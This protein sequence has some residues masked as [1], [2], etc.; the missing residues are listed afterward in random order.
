MSACVAQDELRRET[1]MTAQPLLNRAVSLH[2]AGQLAEAERLYGEVLEADPKSFPAHYMFAVLLYQQQRHPAALQAVEAALR[3]NPEV[4]EALALHGVLALGAGDHEKALASTSKVVAQNPQDAEAWHNRGVILAGMGRLEEALESYDKALALRPTPEAWTNRGAAL[5][6][7]KRCGD[8]LK[9]Y[10]AALAF[11]ANLV[12]ALAGRGN[13]L[14]ELERYA[15]AVETFDAVLV[16]APSAFEAWSNRGLALH[17]MGRFADALASYDKAIEARSDYG[18]AWTNRGK[19]LYSLERYEDA[20]GSYDRAVALAPDSVQAWHARAHTLRTLHRLPEALT[21]AEKALVAETDFLP[22]LF[23]RGWLL[24]ELNRVSE[25]LAAMKSAA[26]LTTRLNVRVEPPDLPHRRRHDEEQRDYLESLGATVV[27]GEIYFAGGERVEG[28]A[29]N[30]ENAEGACAQW[31]ETRPRLA[32]IDNFLTDTALEKL[33]RFC[34]GST[35]WGTTYDGGYVG[36]TPEQGF[37]CPL[38]AQVAE[39]L[40]DLV[41]AIIGA[42]PLRMLW[43]FKY[44]SRLGGTKIHA[45]QAAINVNFWITPDEANLN[46][47]SGGMVIWDVA[48]PQDW[49]PKRYNGDEEAA[50]AF[51][52]QAGAKPITVPHRSN[53]AVIFDSDLF[54][55]TDAINFK[56]GYLNRRIN[57]TM[58]F[59]RRTYYGA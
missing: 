59:G 31:H 28:P 10:D 51:L 57:L 16:Q 36:A 41:P 33:R 20:L 24:C 19:A 27:K 26:E 39:E 52:K 40:R 43:G 15:E 45:D 56:E 12:P 32:I 5:L 58:L 49:E 44:D 23:L 54:H 47:E 48:A 18:P 4:K 55:E 30:M 29:V 34:W 22:S 1:D 38:L 3:L 6:N 37:A 42:H 35:I 53:R 2:Q 14:M 50:R 7:L 8:A 21:S 25:G 13:A 46:P 17:E 9:C 11:D